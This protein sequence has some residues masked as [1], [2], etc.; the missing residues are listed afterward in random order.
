MANQR[1]NAKITIG[2]VVDKSF[3]RNIGL[4]RSGF[5]SVGDKIREVKERQKELSKQRKVLQAQGRAVDHLDREYEDLERTLASLTRKQERWARAMRASSRVG[6]DFSRMTADVGRTVRRVGFLAAGAATGLFALTNSTASLGDTV[7]KNARKFGMGIEAYQELRFAAER[8]GVSVETFDSSMTAFTKRMGEAAQGTGAARDAL[9][10]LG[11]PIE[12]IKHL[13][14]EDQLTLIAERLQHVESPA[15]RAAI[16]SDL[17]SRAGVGMVNMLGDGSKGLDDLRKRAR[18]LGHVLDED[19]ARSSEAFKDAQLDAQL[20]V[21]G[22]K[23]TI[24][25]EFLPVVTGA[26]R[27]FSDWTAANREDVKAFAGTAAEKLGD[28]LPKVGAMAKGMGEVASTIGRVVSKTADLVGGWQNFGVVIGGV[29]ASRT[30]LSV[31]RFA[32]SVGRLGAALFSLTGV[33]PLV[34][35]GI[36]AIGRALL[37]NPIGLAIAGIAG[38]ATLIYRNWDKVGPWFKDLWGGVR[39][40]FG[41]IGR[42]VSGVWRGDFDAAAKGLGGAWKGAKSTLGT[43]LKGVVGVFKWA[44]KK[45]IKPITDKL[46]WT[47]GIERAWKGTKRIL[48]KALQGVQSGFRRAGAFVRDR[49]SGAMEGAADRTRAAWTGAKSTVGRALDGLGGMFK[50]AWANGIKPITDKLGVTDEIEAAWAGAKSALG[51]ALDGIQTGFKGLGAFV[52]DVFAGDM[53][54]AADKARAAWEGAKTKVGSALDGLG[55][56]FEATWTNGIKP[57][58]DKLGV[59]DEIEAAWAG[60]KSALGTALDGIQTG[61]KGLGAFVG[62]VFTGDMEGAAD[63]A[64]TAWEGAKTKVGSALDGLGVVFETTWTNG[65]KPITDKLGVTDEIEAAWAGAKSALGT[66]LDGIQTGFKGLGAFVGDVFTGDMEGAADKARTAWEGAKTKVGSALDGLGVV[67]ETTWTNGI[68]PI[69]DKLGVTDEIEAAWAGAKSALGTAL[70]G[71][72]AGFESVWTNAIQPVVDKLSATGGIVSAWE[73]VKSGVGTVLEWIGDKFEWLLEKVQ[74]VID[75]LKWTIEKAGAVG[76][77]V[78]KM[79]GP[80]GD[81][82]PGAAE[83]PRPHLNSKPGKPEPKPEPNY[84]GGVFGR[85][86]IRVGEQGEETIW[87]TQGGFVATARATERLAR[88]AREAAPLMG[89]GMRAAQAALPRAA[90]VTAASMGLIGGGLDMAQA[91]GTDMAERAVASITAPKVVRSEVSAPKPAE[92]PRPQPPAV[93]QNITIHA[94]G[95]S[96]EEV[97][98]EVERRK[99]MAQSGALFDLPHDYGQYGGA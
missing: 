89:E 73:G 22:L 26:M 13:K 16:A 17:F 7:A 55:G 98:D 56:M 19:A 54:G 84:L 5:D 18:E 2:G 9:K 94:A 60:A 64:R 31:G 38:A 28:V 39:E 66:A 83:G 21:G 97:A 74:P 69:T 96:A 44:W 30:I 49:F 75:A 62:D 91:R 53:E 8:S 99:R 57:I 15:E 48:G 87:P 78:G 37:L 88:L 42:F 25:S 80:A 76:D 51:T 34:V 12:K 27:Q 85:K 41:G 11:L 10:A 43:A 47:E 72:G 35:A 23:N 50:S 67:F 77:A 3:K 32:L 59:T 79:F 58:T 6:S 65:I 29:L 90:S 81:A 68:K 40:T 92:A 1:L 52:G 82:T 63:K 45:G 86:P 14:P 4:I 70:D 46:G 71:I 36:K 61:F 95:A 33:T 24:G 20:A 93:T